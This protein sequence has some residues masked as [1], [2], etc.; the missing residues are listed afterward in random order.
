MVGRLTP[1]QQACVRFA[2]LLPANRRRYPDTCPLSLDFLCGGL[3][4]GVGMCIVWMLAGAALA[5]AILGFLAAVA[6]EHDEQERVRLK[7]EKDRK[8]LHDLED[9]YRSYY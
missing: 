7:R 8:N 1:N 4:G 3:M 6:E 9:W 5:L 2:V